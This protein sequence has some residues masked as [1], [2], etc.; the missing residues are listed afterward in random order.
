MKL[1][2]LEARV[3]LT[4]AIALDG[5]R[6][7][8]PLVQKF[9]NH[10]V[11]IQTIQDF[12]Q[13]LVHHASLGHCLLKGNCLRPLVWESRAGATDPNEPTE[14]LCLD[15]DGISCYSD[16]NSF[17]APWGL[18]TVEHTYFFSWTPLHPPLQPF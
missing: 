5:T 15:L 6:T 10:E 11:S 7:N 12:H 9:R 17:L 8:Y 3:P 2:F 1:T 4:K 13:A 16:I 14:W 18:H